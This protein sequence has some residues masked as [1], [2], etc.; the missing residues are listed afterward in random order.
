M[1]IEF[2]KRGAETRLILI[3]AGWSTDARFY[4]ECIVDGWDTAVIYD[5][6]DMAFPGIPAQYTTV[7]VFAY[8]LGV[9]VASKCDIDAALRVAVCGTPAPVSDYLGIPE[10]I[11]S[12]TATGLS[13]ASLSKFHRRMAGDRA[14]YERMTRLLAKD[15]DVDSLKEELI[16]ISAQSK[17]EWNSS[18]R[19][20]RAY[21][22][23]K[24]NIFPVENQIRFWSEF[25]DAQVIRLQSPH[26]I[27]LASVVRQCIPVCAD[28][29]HGFSRAVSSYNKNAVVQKEVCQRIEEI[30]AGHFTP[31][32]R[33]VGSLLEIGAG[34]GMLTEHWCRVLCPDSATY[35]DLVDMRKF[36]KANIEQYVV[37]DAELWLE[38]SGGKFDVIVS[39]STIQ[40][41]ADPVGFVRSVRSHLNAGGIAVL[42]TF[43]SGNLE[44]LDSIR[45]SPVIYR[46]AAEYGAIPGVVVE[47]WTRTLTFETSRDMLM[48]LLNTGVSPRSKSKDK[49]TEAEASGNP[50][51]IVG[52]PTSLTYTPLILVIENK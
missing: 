5:Y 32:N 35:V 1:K 33:S 21:V 6:R 37:E 26:Y 40:W 20:H 9:W 30:L 2:I 10:H 4:S 14:S 45:T 8:S 31:G 38:K 47:Q 19:W 46:S 44:Q 27:D 51:R 52:L 28:I 29:G 15:P 48:H 12:G 34:S 23:M 25:S 13:A 7:F 49:K 50:L 22:A 17:G 42:S 16:S 3:F 39:A 36:N 18:M 11:F 24:D 43:V 41:F